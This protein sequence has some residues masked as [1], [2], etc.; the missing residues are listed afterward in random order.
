MVYAKIL[1]VFYN[2]NSFTA[3]FSVY[4]LQNKC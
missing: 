4:V 1:E 2:Y 3:Y